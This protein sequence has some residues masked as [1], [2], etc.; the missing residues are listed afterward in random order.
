M[1][2]FGE[3]FQRCGVKPTIELNS[4]LARIQDHHASGDAAADTER[5]LNIVM[6]LIRQITADL[7]APGVTEKAPEDLLIPVH[8]NDGSLQLKPIHQCTFCDSD[9]LKKGRDEDDVTDLGDN[10]YIVH[11]VISE[12]LAKAL[13]ARCKHYHQ[14]Q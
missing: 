13:H 12:A 4:I 9:W 14:G 10:V 8:M 3:L 6:S 7:E 1:Q 5:D 2:E 11:S